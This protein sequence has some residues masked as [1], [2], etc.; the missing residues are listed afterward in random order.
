MK[1][2]TIISIVLVSLLSALSCKKGEETPE[3]YKPRFIQSNYDR[4]TI[5]DTRDTKNIIGYY[6]EWNN[7]SNKFIKNSYEFNKTTNPEFA[8]W[9]DG[10]TDVVNIGYSA[11][12]LNRANGI[13]SYII[14]SGSSSASVATLA[15]FYPFVPNTW[16]TANKIDGYALFYERYNEDIERES[17]FFFDFDNASFLFYRNGGAIE[18]TITSLI[19]TPNGNMATDPIDWKLADASF[20]FTDADYPDKIRIIVLDYDAQKY[21]SFTRKLGNVG[22][23]GRQELLNTT[24]QPISDLVDVWKF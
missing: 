7:T 2:I 15:D 4:V 16:K 14:S 18:G 22:D 13:T 19:K 10:V 24:W 8:F 3:I 6:Y 17:R 12:F 21:V 23:A 5:F 9:P 11:H 1:K 20:E